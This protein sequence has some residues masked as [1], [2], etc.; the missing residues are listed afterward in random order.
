MGFYM[1]D[2]FAIKSYM[3]FAAQYGLIKCAKT[4]TAGWIVFF[5]IYFIRF[6]N[7]KKNPT[8]NYYAMLLLVPAVFMGMNKVF[9]ITGISYYSSLLN[10]LLTPL[11]GYIY[12][13][14]IFVLL[15][16]FIYLDHKMKK[17]VYA[18]PHW[19]N[20]AFIQGCIHHVVFTNDYFSLHYLKRVQVYITNENIS[21]FSGGLFHPFIV[22]P[23]IIVNSWDKEKQ[24]IVLC[25]E[26][27]HIKSGHIFWKYF[28]SLIKIYW[29]INPLIYFFEKQLNEDMEMVC[30]EKSIFCTHLPKAEYGKLLLDMVLVLKTVYSQGIATFVNRNDYQVLKSRI[31]SLCIHQKNDYRK[32]FI[33]FI[34]AFT[35]LVTVI[36]ATSYPRY[37][38]FTDASLFN[39]QLEYISELEHS[40]S[41]LQIKDGRLFID[42]NIFRQTLMDKNITGDYV[43]IYFDGIMKVPGSGGGGNTARVS[44]KDFSD[45]TYLAL[46]CIENDILDIFLKYIL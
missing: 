3:D 22:L 4:M 35:G 18:L 27:I 14:V 20:K 29:W 19:K 28:F 31:G 11:L 38:K 24:K 41:G 23:N 34:A 16:H 13:S 8:I 15:V 37:T 43:Y 33:I 6:L 26:L 10:F 44:T 21:P 7:K 45:V 17:D 39:E 2:W 30:D 46:D 36:M 5:F 12:F 9:F 42:D 25:H 40:V 32:Y 1:I